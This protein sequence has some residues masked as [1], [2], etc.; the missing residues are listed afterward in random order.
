MRLIHALWAD[1]CFQFRQ[2]FFL[3]YAILTVMYLILLSFVPIES[4]KIVLPVVVFS[5]PAMLG[6]IFIGGIIMLEKIQGVLSVI[7]V[8]PLRAT[9]YLLSKM[10]SLILVS[11]LAGFAITA[12]SRHETVNWL[13]LFASLCLSSG[14]F[15]LF[16]IMICAGCQT[17]N[18][19]FV[20]TI[21]YMLLLMLPCFSLIG[22]PYSWLFNIVPS[23]AALHLMMGAY[24]GMPFW[25]SASLVL[26]LTGCIY[27][28]LKGAIRIFEKK[29]VYQD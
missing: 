2:G 28:C 11:V 14:F 9:E 24:T 29:I 16:G 6:L 8:T 5:D 12:F 23:V 3:V 7:V 19:Y 18:Q 26:Y 20:R 15:T 10:L 1:I 13:L 21:P 17:I 25:E 4:M 22:F 27:L